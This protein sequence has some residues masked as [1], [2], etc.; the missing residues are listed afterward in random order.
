MNIKIKTILIIATIFII[1]SILLVLSFNYGKPDHQLS[2]NFQVTIK[3]KVTSSSDDY[4]STTSPNIV[5]VYHS[6]YN[7]NNLCEADLIE[8]ANISWNSNKDEGEYIIT[9]ELPVEQEVIVTPNCNGCLHERVFVSKKENLHEIDL[10]WDTSTCREERERYD[11]SEEASERA[12][13][14]FDSIESMLV[15]QD[16][17]PN[18]TNSIKVDVQRGR[19]NI[20]D[21]S[22]TSNGNESLFEAYYALFYAWKAFYK[23]DAFELNTCLKNIENELLIHS[24]SCYTIPY[25]ASEGYKSSSSAY[26]SSV[27]AIKRLDKR[28]YGLPE[29]ENLINAI[30]GIYNDR[31]RIRTASRTCDDSLRLI[32]KSLEY[33]EPYCKRAKFTSN[34]VNFT[35][36][37]I[38]LMVG[39]IIGKFGRRW[40][41]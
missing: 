3:G 12:R 40:D 4:D 26:N 23:M 2:E 8:L 7:L 17:S 22:T 13:N 5:R 36:V 30:D 14:L 1:I 31:G 41:E 39:I 6:Y 28:S 38:A 10:K 21:A 37:L 20:R 19:D 25:E 9:F 34:F 27:D 33:Q 16:F 32:S 29:F 24:D 11:D 18:M 35:L 15:S